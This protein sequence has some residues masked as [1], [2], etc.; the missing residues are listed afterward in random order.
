MVTP[1]VDIQTAGT[2][3]QDVLT[4]L[5]ELYPKRLPRKIAR[6][7]I[8]ANERLLDR[9]V[10][11]KLRPYPPR[12][13]H[14]PFKWSNDPI[15]N[16]RA[17]RWWFANKNGPHVRTGALARAWQA[18]V[19]Y[20]PAE[21]QVVVSVGNS[22]P[23]ASYVVGAAAFGYEQ[24]PSHAAT[25]WVNIGTTGANVVL[26]VAIQIENDLRTVIDEELRR[27]K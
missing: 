20:S 26:E 7:I 12:V 2:G 23:G 3:I 22:A 24:V 1:R 18:D 5:K 16:A 6:V 4:A 21:S 9:L 11:E 10:D 14:T 25:G 8:P 19:D 27:L 13:R 15:K 17:R